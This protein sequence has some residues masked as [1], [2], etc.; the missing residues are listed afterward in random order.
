[1]FYVIP[2]RSEYFPEKSIT[3]TCYV[4][5]LMLF[6]ENMRLCNPTK[7]VAQTLFF[8]VRLRCNVAIIR[9]T[10]DFQRQMFAY[11]ALFIGVFV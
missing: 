3:R 8:N 9:K 10:Y 2:H 1:M 6:P 5:K 7:S 11:K 4:T